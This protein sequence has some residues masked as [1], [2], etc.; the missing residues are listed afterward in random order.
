VL[1]TYEGKKSEKTRSQT[2]EQEKNKELTIEYLLMVAKYQKIS[3]QY[4]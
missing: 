3:V 4:L 1:H 2:S